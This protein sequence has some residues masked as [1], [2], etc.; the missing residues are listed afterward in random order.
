[1]ATD[2]DVKF[3]NEKGYFDFSFAEDG[4][5]ELTQGLDSALVITFYTNQRADSTE[6]STPQNRSGW[7]GDAFNEDGSKMGSRIWLLQNVAVNQTTLNKAIDYTTKAYQ[8]LLDENYIDTLNVFGESS[9][10]TI[11]ITIQTVID[12]DACQTSFTLWTNTNEL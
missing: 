2:I 9:L 10:S 1:M 4:D 5:F 8:W 7:W 3:T 12:S 6:V 11:T